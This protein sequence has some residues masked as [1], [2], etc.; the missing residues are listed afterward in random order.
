MMN[1]TQA[2]TKESN[3]KIPLFCVRGVVFLYGFIWMSACSGWGDRFAQE[4]LW[5]ADRVM[6]D[7]ALLVLQEECT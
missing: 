1:S 6:W 2:Y 5:R 4:E 7:E 3:K